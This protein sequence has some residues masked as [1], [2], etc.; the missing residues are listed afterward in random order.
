M[1]T[2]TLNRRVRA[3]LAC[4]LTLAACAL[5]AHA[6][7][8][9]APPTSSNIIPEGTNRVL[10]LT[11][12]D[13]K[14]QPVTDLTSAEFKIFDDGKVQPIKNFNPMLAPPPGKIPPPATLILFDLLNS[15]FSQQAYSPPLIVRALERLETADSVYLYLLTIGGDLY[16]VHALSMPQQTA[17]PE[18][19]SAG[20]RP[21]SAP[22]TRQVRPLLDQA[23]QTVYGIRP[24]D[25][26][27]QGI[28]AA[29]TF[30]ALGELGDQLMRVPGPKTILWITPG[31]PNWVD[32]PLGCKDVIFPEGGGNYL[33]GKCGSGCNRMASDTKCV[34]YAPFL[35]HFGAK[36]SRSDTIVYSVE[37]NTTGSVVPPNRGW[38]HDTLQKLADLSGGRLYINGEIEKAIAQSLQVAGARYQLTYRAPAPNGKY[39]KLR[40]E[41]SRKGV[42]INAPRGYF[43][44]QLQQTTNSG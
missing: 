24:K 18:G 21:G 8:P 17:A 15:P 7:A 36:L 1:L 19:T 2:Q 41:C 44:E 40:V 43:A 10:D 3:S 11:A 31:A 14:G 35:Q 27:D 9:T 34:D 37:V 5:L 12:L 13:E 32:Y 23:M 6:Q 16:P 20:Q 26:R 39:H 22:W 4:G 30:L 29:S 25:Y 28:R 42:R 38:P 33:A